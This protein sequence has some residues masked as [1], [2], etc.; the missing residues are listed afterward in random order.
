MADSDVAGEICEVVFL[1]GLADQAH[2]GARSDSLTVRSSYSGALLPSMLQGIDAEECHT[3]DVFA[4]DIHPYHAASLFHRVC[5]HIGRGFLVPMSVRT[6][7]I[8]LHDNCR[9]VGPLIQ[10]LSKSLLYC[11]T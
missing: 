3:G 8:T 11:S 9:G 10:N 1:E 5:V 2:G 7:Q 4:F 6:D